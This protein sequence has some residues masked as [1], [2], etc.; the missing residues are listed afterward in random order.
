MGR[1]MSVR[2]SSV[3]PMPNQYAD[4]KELLWYSFQR[5][6]PREVAFCFRYLVLIIV[7][8]LQRVQSLSL[9]IG[10]EVEYALERL[11]VHTGPCRN[12]IS[13]I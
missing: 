2:V 10:V 11:S 4:N 3:K 5:E 13:L 8:L 1:D 6:K 9:F 12:K 7:T